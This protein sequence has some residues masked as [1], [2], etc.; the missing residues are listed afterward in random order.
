MFSFKMIY[1]HL[2]Y[3]MDFENIYIDCLVPRIYNF[4]FVIYIIELIKSNLLTK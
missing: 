4:L 1:L 3:K 2:T